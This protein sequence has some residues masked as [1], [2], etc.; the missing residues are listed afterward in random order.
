MKYEEMTRSQKKSFNSYKRFKD[1]LG[2]N[3]QSTFE[4]WYN[5][6][7]N[8]QKFIC[9]ECGETFLGNA[10]HYKD[11]MTKC[12]KCCNKQRGESLRKS[13]AYKEGI[14]RRE[15]EKKYNRVNTIEEMWKDYLDFTGNTKT[16]N[17]HANGNCL[18]LEYVCKIC[19]HKGW[20]TSRYLHLGPID[21]FGC[22]NGCH[23]KKNRSSIEM[24]IKEFFDN[25]GLKENKDYIWHDRSILKSDKGY[26]IEIDFYFPKYKLAIEVNG[27]LWHSYNHFIETGM[28]KQEAKMYHYKKT[29]QCEDQGVHLIH[30][31]QHEWVANEERIKSIIKGELGLT[32]N[33]IYARNCEFKEVSQEE[34]RDFVTRLSVLRYRNA[35]LKYGLYHKDKLVM[36]MA[37][38]YCQSGKGSVLK[39]KLEVVRSVTELDTIV[40]GG[41]SK[42]LKHI[43][44]IL[45]EKYPD[46]HELVYYV[47]YDKHL[48]K[49]LESTNAIFDGYSGPSCQNYCRSTVTLVNNQGKE[50]TL[51][52]GK[53]YS[54]IPSHHKQIT[55]AIKEGKI[56]ALYTSGTKKFHYNI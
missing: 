20:Q 13:E 52:Y 14:K 25:L 37:I 5:N 56:L 32:A 43:I 11:G 36:V 28:T 38:D 49:S 31:W 16:E 9:T 53:V 17:N 3:F 23:R 47:D 42:L 40:V 46:I 44:P 33:K 41:T 15:E 21:G 26:P 6:K 50:R 18:K 35:N 19:G 22:T 4:E 7:H 30:V 8:E 51:Y 2:D 45:N 27:D 24:K 39:D 1:L 54:R 55:E 12:H 29:K 10:Y 34:Y 48:G